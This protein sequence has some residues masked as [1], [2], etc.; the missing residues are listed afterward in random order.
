MAKDCYFVEN[1]LAFTAWGKI[2]GKGLGFFFVLVSQFSQQIFTG[3]QQAYSSLRIRS[4]T[5][6]S[7]SLSADIFENYA[8]VRFLVL[9]NSV[10][11]ILVYFFGKEMRSRVALNS[12]AGLPANEC[13]HHQR[14]ELVPRM[15]LQCGLEVDTEMQCENAIAEMFGTPRGRGP[16]DNLC[17]QGHWDRYAR[18]RSWSGLCRGRGGRLQARGRFLRVVP[19]WVQVWYLQRCLPPARGHWLVAHSLLPATEERRLNM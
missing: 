2:H 11:V 4:A 3:A 15:N 18:L 16:D 17:P 14:Q 10:Q 6:H 1:L 7:F 5:R 12:S 8:A 19:Q 13:A 9:T